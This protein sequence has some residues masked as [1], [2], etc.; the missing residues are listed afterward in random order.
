MSELNRTCPVLTFDH[1]F[2]IYRRNGRQV[3]PLIMPPSTP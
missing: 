1:H 3:L 2:R